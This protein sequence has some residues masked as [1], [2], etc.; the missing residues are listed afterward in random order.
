LTFANEQEWWDQQ[1]NMARRGI[2][3]RMDPDR[4][5]QLKADLFAGFQPH[6][7]ADGRTPITIGT[8]FAFGVKKQ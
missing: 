1:W 7:Q 6:K 8:L 4:R 3:E 5:E 2:F